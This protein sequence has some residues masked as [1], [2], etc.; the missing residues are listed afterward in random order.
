MAVVLPIWKVLMEALIFL[1]SDGWIAKEMCREARAL[2]SGQEG[3]L[4]R[5]YRALACAEGTMYQDAM[6]SATDHRSANSP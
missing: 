1:G 5:S 3:L 4:L 2:L 6:N